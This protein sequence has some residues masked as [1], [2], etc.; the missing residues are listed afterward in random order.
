MTDAASEG[1]KQIISSHSHLAGGEKN[2]RNR[3]EA[4]DACNGG[5]SMLKNRKSGSRKGEIKLGTVKR[6]YIFVAYHKDLFG[7]TVPSGKPSRIGK[8]TASDR[9][10]V[11]SVLSRFEY[12]HCRF[13]SLDLKT[14][15][16]K[17]T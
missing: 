5:I 2:I 7:I 12:F 16:F 10:G 11:F 6:S 9:D 13:A 15:L 14:A 3:I 8:N 17:F 4:L 1:E